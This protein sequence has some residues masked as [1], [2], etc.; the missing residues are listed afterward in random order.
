MNV[1]PLRDCI[2]VTKESTGET[3]TASGLVLVNKVE[4]VLTGT[5]LA[6]GSGKVADNGAV[7]PMEVKVGD[8][9]VFHSS[10]TTEVQSDNGP[11]LVLREDN[12][13]AVLTKSVNTETQ[14]DGGCDY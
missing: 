7:I 12:L 14:S 5:V 10:V 3:R 4:P 2:V 11:V 13:L 1:Q 8:K 9:V 6:V